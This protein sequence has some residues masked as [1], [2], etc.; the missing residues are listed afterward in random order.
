MAVPTWPTA[1]PQRYRVEGNAESIADGRLKSQTDAGPGKLRP[2]T[3]ARPDPLTVTLRMTAA[4]LDIL[5]AFVRDDLG[6][7][8]LPFLVPAARGAATWLVRFADS[9]PAWVNVGGDRY[10]V[11]LSL[12]I[13]P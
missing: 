8:T 12:E 11:T 7:G 4:Q 1:L 9:L 13:L 6:R 2:R 10:N 5:A 3:S